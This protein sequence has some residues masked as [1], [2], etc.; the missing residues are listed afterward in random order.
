MNLL[1]TGANGFIGKALTR[2]LLDRP[3]SLPNCSEVATRLT[4]LD[5]RFEGD[6]TPGVRR[7]TGSIADP[8]VISRAF[9]QPVDIVFHLASV[10]GGMAEQNYELAR[11]VNID[12]T[13]NLLEASRTQARAFSKPPTF[14]FASSIAVLGNALPALVDDSTPPRPRMSYGAQKLIGEILL[15]DFHRRGWINGRALRLPGVVARPPQPTGQLSAFM[16]DIIRELAAGRRF[17]CP[18]AAD[19]TLWL[20]SVSCAVENLLRAA[21]LDTTSLTQ[22]AGN[23]RPVWTLPALQTSLAQL[24]DAIAQVCGHDAKR[25]VSFG[26]DATLQAHFG[27]YPPLHTPA[28]ESVGFAHDGDLPTLVQRA[29]EG[30]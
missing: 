11:L 7:L 22:A 12:A 30:A 10:P 15:E 2:R 1:I 17:F 29:L 16:S 8:S 18:I 23:G 14:V 21:A 4:L 5:L 20:I 6:E 27:R 24:V 26:S 3:I 13:L 9:E 25:R 19:S 28:A